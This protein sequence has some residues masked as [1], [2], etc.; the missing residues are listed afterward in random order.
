VALII[1]ICMEERVDA[2]CVIIP[3]QC[4]WCCHHAESSIARVHPGSHDEC[5]TAPGGR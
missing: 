2:T 5:S 1:C 4:L 3:G